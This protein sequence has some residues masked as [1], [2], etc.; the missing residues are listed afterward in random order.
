MIATTVDCPLCGVVIL[1]QGSDPAA[2]V[3]AAGDAL[4][5]HLD[6]HHQTKEA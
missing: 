5:T 4:A 3:S 6:D 2:A 1:G